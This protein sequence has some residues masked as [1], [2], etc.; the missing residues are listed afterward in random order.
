MIEMR[1]GTTKERMKSIQEAG[2]AREKR[3][4]LMQE[5]GALSSR[6]SEL[7]DQL[8]ESVVTL[9]TD[10]K[11]RDELNCLLMDENK[12]LRDQNR[13]LF[14]ALNIKPTPA[15]DIMPAAEYKSFNERHADMNENSW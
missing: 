9:L 3:D 13:K 10:W 15:L 8:N 5:L 2:E 7:D 12:E 4:Q 1:V 6:I 11:P 14:R